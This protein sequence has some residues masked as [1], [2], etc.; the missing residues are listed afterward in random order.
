MSEIKQYCTFYLG[1]AL[2]GVEVTRV[3]EVIRHQEMTEVPLASAVVRGLINLRGSIVSCIDL[4]ARFGM[5]PAPEGVLPLNVVTQTAEG[6]VSLQVDRIGDVVEVTNDTLEL[7]PET[8]QGE[9]RK[10]IQGVY[11][12]NGSLLR[13]L[14]VERVLD[15]SSPTQTS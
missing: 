9:A 14:D 13:S 12:L 10:L 11:K 6:L 1:S 4:R 3:Q 5:D 2:F 7:P 15:F 8:L